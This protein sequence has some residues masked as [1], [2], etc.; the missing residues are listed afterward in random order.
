M[1]RSIRTAVEASAPMLE[2]T[3]QFD[4]MVRANVK[5]YEEG[6]E[7]MK[8]YVRE[9]YTEDEAAAYRS[10]FVQGCETRREMRAAS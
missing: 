4:D 5:G 3:R 10:G 9:H 6:V 7:G 8:E 1:K 2:T